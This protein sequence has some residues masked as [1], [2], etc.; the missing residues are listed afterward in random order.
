MLENTDQN[1]QLLENAVRRSFSGRHKWDGKVGNCRDALVVSCIK[2]GCIKQTVSGFLTYFI[3]D[4]VYDKA[5][6][7]VG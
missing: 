1:P 6:K 4:T 7:C 5:P 2:C 3:N